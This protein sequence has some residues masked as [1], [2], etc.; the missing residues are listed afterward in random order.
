MDRW[1]RAANT[2]VVDWLQ[3]EGVER[4]IKQEKG[5]SDMLTKLTGEK[6]TVKSFYLC[7]L[8]PFLFHFLI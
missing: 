3:W 6:K 8:S 5:K 1:R 7:Y 4:A 2:V